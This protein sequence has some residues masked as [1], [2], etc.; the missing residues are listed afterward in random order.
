[1]GAISVASLG[2]L[3]KKNGSFRVIHDATLGL[4]VN[5][6]IK[7]QGQIRT[8][9]ADGLEKSDAGFAWSMLRP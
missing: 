1:M 3:E 5:S 6:R 8:P 7:V 2:A 4:A 9:M